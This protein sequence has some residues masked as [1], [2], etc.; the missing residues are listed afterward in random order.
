M[1]KKIVIAA[2]AAVALLVVLNFTRVGSHAKLW[3]HQAGVA[4]QAQIPPEQEIA[5]LELEL[6]DKMEAEQNR[7]FGEKV[8][9]KLEVKKLDVEVKGLREAVRTE[10]KRVV[11]M[12]TCLEGN[13]KYVV[14]DGGKFKREELKD[15]LDRSAVTLQSRIELLASKEEELSL[16]KKSYD[17]HDRL[18]RELELAR[19]QM[20]NELTKLKADLAREKR[21]QVAEKKPTSSAN[22]E[23]LR[24]DIDAVRNSLDVMTV[25]REE[26]G[27]SESPVRDHEARKAKQEK[28]DA[29][30]KNLNVD[31]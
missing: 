10:T 18:Y 17:E 7:L 8:E 30:I 25:R 24:T 6:K 31:E 27:K 9:R 21:L 20:Q 19:T 13:D 26:Q 5:R 29:F 15:E 11:T 14:Y 4:I 2:V 16:A 3:W 22:L 1:C 23:R 12:R 28:L